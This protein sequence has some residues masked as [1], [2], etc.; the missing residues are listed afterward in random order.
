MKNSVYIIYYYIISN[1]NNKRN[2]EST[3]FC[4][5]VKILLSFREG[6]QEEN[7]P[8]P[9]EIQQLLQDFHQLL[10][11]HCGWNAIYLYLY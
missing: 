4:L 2:A 7:C 9:V 11:T 10:S 3:W 1:K 8:C 6:E 5:K